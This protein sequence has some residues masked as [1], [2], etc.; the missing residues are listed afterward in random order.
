MQLQF[1][2]ANICVHFQV[3]ITIWEKYVNVMYVT[4]P[5]KV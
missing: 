2:L 5:S 4:Q 1:P 3:A